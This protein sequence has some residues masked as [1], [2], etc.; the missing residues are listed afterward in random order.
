MADLMAALGLPVVDRRADGARHDQPHAAD[1]SRRCGARSL[2]DRR[3]RDGRCAERRQPRRDRTYGRVA[4]LG[5]MP[6][7]EPFTPGALE[8]VGG[9]R[10]SIADGRSCLRA[11]CNDR[12]TSSTAIARCVW[13]PY[14]QMQTRAG[15]A[16]DRPR[17]GRLPLHR[18]RPPAARR[19]LVVVGEHSRPLASAAERRRW[20]SRRS[21][22]ST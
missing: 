22:S 9:V 17:R 19:H 4:V 2:H 6:R 15:A 11:C 3:R 5:E 13:H 14:T 12:R 18:G 10:S 20:P 7:F 1:A 16:A 21:S 8:R